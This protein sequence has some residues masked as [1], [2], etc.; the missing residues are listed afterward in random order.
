M[1]LL[2]LGLRTIFP[3][4]DINVLGMIILDNPGETEELFPDEGIRGEN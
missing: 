2:Q 4:K 1:T 3:L